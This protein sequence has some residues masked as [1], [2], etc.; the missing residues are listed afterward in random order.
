M[1]I[2]RNVIYNLLYQ[3]ANL[4]LPLITIPYIS[5]VLGP[6]GVG[7]QAF[8]LSVV[9]YFLL[10]GTL[11]LSM[12]GTRE[13]AYHRDNP[14]DLAKAFWSIFT[15]R[16]ICL[17]VAFLLYGIFV[18]FVDSNKIAFGIQGLLIISAI[19]D[20]SWFFL[21]IEEVKF[22]L[23][24]GILLR[25]LSIILIFTLIR[26]SQ[27]AL[28]YIFITA[29][30]PLAVNL[31]LFIKIKDYN[32]RFSPLHYS[33]LIFHL[34]RSL[35]LFV[36]QIAT[37]V[38]LV[39]DKTMLGIFTTLAQ[40]GYYNQ[41]EKLVKTVLALVTS[42]N[43]VL[44]PRMSNMF[45]KKER[46]NMDRMMNSVLA[47]VTIITIPMSAGMILIG[48]D[49][50]RIFLG[51]GFNATKPVLQTLSVLIILISISSV[52]GT[53]YLLPTNRMKAYTS[54]VVLGAVVN[55][56]LNLILIPSYGALG[57]AFSSVL[58]EATVTTSQII[59]VRKSIYTKSYIL[60]TGQSLIASLIMI[61][62][63]L[64]TKRFLLIEGVSLISIQVL[65]GIILY[66]G[67]LWVQSNTSLK[68][69]VSNIFKTSKT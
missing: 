5:R 57:A 25:I 41:A 31:S 40:V 44:L 67:C 54:S 26:N 65:I 16:V 22:V 8:T 19:I 38:Y 2:K 18:L 7:L 59:F 48:G 6:S 13:I 68:V 52:T 49:F 9:D 24:R 3:I 42:I 37:Q 11:G 36:P 43:I 35:T 63:V 60:Q 46:E 47:T 45:A 51:E 62:G 21:G 4:F 34:K 27:D 14:V 29:L 15:T 61:I 32:L 10:A 66:F 20:I 53:Q 69:L 64:A 23:L 56:L 55:L 17:T 12:Y 33:E 30:L 39:L 50:I 1:S 28:R 58:A